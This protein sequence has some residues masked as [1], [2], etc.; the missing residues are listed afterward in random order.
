MLRHPSGDAQPHS[1]MMSLPSIRRSPFRGLRHP[2]LFWVS[3]LLAPALW[4]VF[5]GS[6]NL[7]ELIVGAISSLLTLIFLVFV[8]R[9]SNE[10]LT[11]RPLDL[12][13]LWRIP[14]YIAVDVCGVTLVA[15]KDLFHVQRAQSLYRVCGF[16][17][18][19]HDP[20]RKA[21]TVLAVAYTTASPNIIVL[22]IDPSQSR[23]LFHQIKSS[24]VPKMTQALG[25]KS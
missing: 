6:F 21:R 12:I 25:A 23:M 18:S 2:I 4:I 11:L 22:G 1:T 14:W 20:L 16:D 7:H 19:D 13:Q 9:S 17:S 8:C 5:V 15:V 10:K 24:A 3:V